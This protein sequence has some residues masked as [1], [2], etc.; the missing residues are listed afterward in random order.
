MLQHNARTKTRRPSVRAANRNPGRHFVNHW[1]ALMVACEHV[2]CSRLAR[3]LPR[4]FQNVMVEILQQGAALLHLPASFLYVLGCGQHNRRVS[5]GSVTTCETARRGPIVGL[6]ASIEAVEAL[7]ILSGNRAAISRSLTVIDLWPDTKPRSSIA[8]T[9][10]RSLI[11]PIDPRS[12]V[13]PD[14]ATGAATH[15]ARPPVAALC[16]CSGRSTCAGCGS[17]SIARPAGAASIL[18]FPAACR[19]ARRCFAAATPCNSATPARAFRS[20]CL[21]SGWKASPKS[22]PATNT[23]WQRIEGYK[24]TLFPD[25]RAIISGT[26]D[27][28]VARAVY[29]KYVGN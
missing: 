25:A 15:S 21:P 3:E 18:G 13:A 28:A 12:S 23:C 26:D 29:A 19:A 4:R 7:N 9:K 6:I 14:N 11:A 2:V 10:P 24:L 27:P 8:P 20:M 17:G 16:R 5:P 1:T 22:L